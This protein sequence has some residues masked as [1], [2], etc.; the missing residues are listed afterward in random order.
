MISRALG[1]P[2][3]KVV[4]ESISSVNEWIYR[5]TSNGKG[6]KAIIVWNAGPLIKELRLDLR[7]DE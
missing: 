7:S 3:D 6:G 4:L 2:V 5:F 1:N